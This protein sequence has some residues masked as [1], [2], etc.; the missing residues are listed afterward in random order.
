[1]GRSP[2]ALMRYSPLQPPPRSPT[3]PHTFSLDVSTA[4]TMQMGTHS[5]EGWG[6]NLL[7]GGKSRSHTNHPPPGTL[8]ELST[9]E[10]SPICLTLL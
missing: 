9:C 8:Q 1:M 7:D 2:Y 5:L 4:V 10:I 3:S 6:G